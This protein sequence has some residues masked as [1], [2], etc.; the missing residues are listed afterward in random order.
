MT[1]HQP[2]WLGWFEQSSPIVKYIGV[3]LITVQSCQSIFSG[4]LGAHRELHLTPPFSWL[5]IRINKIARVFCHPNLN[6]LAACCTS[7][8]IAQCPCVQH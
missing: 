5:A 4:Q 6:A 3:G 2:K 7:Q 8:C 1:R